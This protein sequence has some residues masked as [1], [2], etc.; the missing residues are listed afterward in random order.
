LLY[1]NT[2]S[3]SKY[4]YKLDNRANSIV[5]QF[6]CNYLLILTINILEVLFTKIWFVSIQK[7]YKLIYSI[8]VSR[9]TIFKKTK[10]KFLLKYIFRYLYYLFIKKDLLNNKLD[11]FNNIKLYKKLFNTK[12]NKLDILEDKN[13]NKIVKYYIL[14][15]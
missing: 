6:V 8:L 2:R 10:I 1:F 7:I 14:L 11:L 3:N 15:K 9:V 13:S 12:I 5:K 4:I